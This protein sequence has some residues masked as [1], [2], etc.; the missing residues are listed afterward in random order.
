MPKQLRT[1]NVNRDFCMTVRE[2]AGWLATSQTIGK[3]DAASPIVLK[4]GGKNYR[5]SGFNIVA[6]K[7]VLTGKRGTR[8]S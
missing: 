2:L 8:D 5:L 7:P 3:F 4:C 6:G 1:A